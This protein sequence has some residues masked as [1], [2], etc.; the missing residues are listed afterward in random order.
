MSTPLRTPW[1]AS[2]VTRITLV[3]AALLV[4]TVVLIAWI[5]WQ[6]SR[7]EVISQARRTMDHTLDVAIDRLRGEERTLRENTELL[8]T[9]AAITHW[10]EAIGRGGPTG[11]PQATEEVAA[12]F[13]P[14]IRSRSDLAQVRLL[15]ADPVGSEVV[16]FDRSNGRVFRVAD[17]LLQSKA[18]RGYYGATM[19]E[20]AGTRLFFPIDLNR[21]HGGLERPFVPTWRVSAPLFTPHGDRAGMVIINAD[22][23]AL[24]AE[25]LA[26]ADSGSV[27]VLARGDGEVILHP[28]TSQCFRFDLGGSRR[29]ENVLPK[30]DGAE[31]LI[32]R[33]EFELGPSKARFEMAITRSLSGLPGSLRH[34]RNELVLL[35]AGIALGAIA[36]TAMFALRFRE[37]LNRLTGLMER[38]AVG[39]NEEL[40]TAR[41]DE[42]GRMARGLRT[43]QER[44][45]ARVRELEQARVA[46]ETSDRQRREL[47]ANMSHEVRTPLNAIIGMGGE[48]D[49]AHL[50]PADREHMAII[51]RSAERLRGLVD[52]LLMHARIGE[53]KLA[54]HPVP[55]DVRTLVN[56]VTQAHLPSARTKGLRIHTIL[57][58]LPPALLLDPLR[59]H[60]IVDNLLGNAVRFTE[61]GQVTLEVGMDGPGTLRIQVAD[62]GPGIPAN[63]RERVFERFERASS[64]EQG[65]GAGLGLAITRR[66]TDLMGGRISMDSEVGRGTRFTVLLPTAA[67]DP[68]ST[69]QVNVAGTRGLRVLHVEDVATNRLLMR[70]WAARWNWALT[71]AESSGSARSACTAGTF[72]LLLLDLELGSGDSGI[73]LARQLRREGRHRYTPILALTA[74]ASDD[75]D[76]EI[77]LAGMN[78]RITKPLDRDALAAAAAWWTD[79]RDD[80]TIGIATLLDQYGVSGT[81]AIDLIQQ[82][83][84]EFAKHRV[85]IGQAIT[86]GDADLLSRTRHQVRPHWQL[87]GLEKGLAALDALVIPV[88]PGT[89]AAVVHWFAA[90]DRAM[91]R[92]QRRSAGITI[93]G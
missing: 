81:R 35:F 72:D 48:I 8:A 46:A 2:I 38:Y 79:E 41:N 47:L 50:G 76:A 44:I 33:R 71:E 23:R 40:P 9:N 37:R 54:L 30:E 18:D 88:T 67:T 92:E 52:D 70:Q 69:V 51:Q 4:G 22:M 19:K 53:G 5:S 80:G 15:G 25:L 65:H 29:M 86:A 84:D 75:T 63:E 36:L 87:L 57:H 7:A 58:D 93:A 45:D 90:C 49:T 64:S 34:R 1:Y 13:G 59:L 74:H 11:I 3:F 73:E 39:S 20:P 10:C 77:L 91:M 89:E 14:L 24:F 26:L 16:R 60:Q 68:G 55:V 6:A 28:D 27:L 78:A 31:V 12:F 42:F 21:E 82:F 85:S 56:D 17:S 66:V 61:V 32:G 43:M 62:T 83:R